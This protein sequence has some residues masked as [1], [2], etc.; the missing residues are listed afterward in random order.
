[1]A[2]KEALEILPA[3]SIAAGSASIHNAFDFD[4]A[5]WCTGYACA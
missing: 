2:F 5:T 4:P 1:M 3:A